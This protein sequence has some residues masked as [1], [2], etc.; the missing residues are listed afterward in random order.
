MKLIRFFALVIA[1]VAALGSPS[2]ADDLA[3]SVLP[4]SRSATIGQ[5]VT[6]FA[7][8]INSSG[9]ALSS[10]TVALPNFPGTFSFQTTNPSTNAVTGTLNGAFSLANG[11]SQS[12]VLALQPQ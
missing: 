1:G 5:T 9:G 6:A 12:L 8:V 10:C 4:L 3:A 2:W 7:T 11:A